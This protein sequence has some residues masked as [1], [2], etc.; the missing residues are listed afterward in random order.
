MNYRFLMVSDEAEDFKRE[1]KISAS[2][3]FKVLHDIIIQSVGFD[4]RDMSSFVICDSNW[5]REVEI[6]S[7]SMDLGSDVDPITMDDTLIN[8]YLEEERQ[9]LLF[10]FDY[11]NER[12]FYLD[13]REIS[14]D[15]DIE[16]P[17]ILRQEGIVPSQYI[18]FADD[19]TIESIT[20]TTQIL[21]DNFYGD[22]MYNEDELDAEGFDGLDG[23][24]EQ[25]SDQID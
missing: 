7:E 21:D 22:D 18:E 16:K 13:L 20:E 2:T 17:Q 14:F 8:E 12:A 24:E 9:K 11:L 23:L 6:T 19:F 1:Y 4:G 15:Q 3:T 10:V 5:N 25:I